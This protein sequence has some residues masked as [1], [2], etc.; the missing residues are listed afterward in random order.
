MLIAFGEGTYRFK[1]GGFYTSNLNYCEAT[2]PF[3]LTAFDCHKVDGTVKFE[4]EYTGG[5]F[6]SVTSQ[7]VEFSLCCNCV[8]N[9]SNSQTFPISL[10]DSIRFYGFFGNDVPEYQRDSIKYQTGIVN[11]VRDEAIK[12][13]TFRSDKL[14]LWLHKRFYSYGLMADRLYVSDYNINNADYNLK[15]FYVVADS[16]YPIKYNGWSRYMKVIDA[17]FKEG[18]QYVFRDRCC[19]NTIRNIGP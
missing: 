1:A 6:G 12:N 3:C 8:Y 16:N 17:K 14:P 9:S 19:S 5:R 15:H 2:P 13:F 10:Q 4:A 7:G 18:Q 11:K